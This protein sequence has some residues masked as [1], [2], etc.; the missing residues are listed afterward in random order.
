MRA[1]PHK[2]DTTKVAITLIP[3]LAHTDPPYLDIPDTQ[4]SN[5][6]PSKQ[7]AAA[8][9]EE[10]AAAAGWDSADRAHLT[11]REES[12]TPGRQNL[13][14]HLREEHGSAREV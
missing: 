5:L 8:E 1:H 7:M 12:A 3:P 6:A 11:H 4:T 9:L 10:D 13:R 2:V 14:H